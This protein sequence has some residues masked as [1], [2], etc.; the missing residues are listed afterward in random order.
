MNSLLRH[1]IAAAAVGAVVGGVLTTLPAHAAD[2]VTIN[3]VAVNDFHG[4]VDSDVVQ[5]AGTVEQLLAD[6]SAGNSLLLSAGDNV[7]ES[8]PASAAQHDDPTIDILNVLGVDASAVGNHEFDD[9]YDNLVNHIM[10]RADFPIL[11]ANV[12][13]ING[14]AAL[15]ASTMYDVSGVRLAVV[16]AVTEHTPELVPPKGI[17]GLTFGDPVGAINGEVDRLN[18]LPESERPE[19]IVAVIHDGAPWGSGDLNG[20]LRDSSF[21]TSL[22]EDT[23]PDVDAI[24]TGHTHNTYVFDAPV[25]GQSGRTR[26]VIQTGFYGSNVGQI[27]LTVAPDTGDVTAYVA[28]NVARVT[29][30]DDSLIGTYPVLAQVSKIRNDAVAFAKAQAEEAV[31]T[32]QQLVVAEAASQDAYANAEAAKQDYETAAAAG[33][34]F[35][36]TAAKI[37][38]EYDAAVATGKEFYATAAKIKQEYDAARETGRLAYDKAAAI[39][40]EY[41]AAVAAVK[42]SYAT[43]A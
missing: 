42:E 2:V 35:Y 32:K 29:A 10:Q 31:I 26:P 43:A 17:E 25:P 16:G 8:L 3:L 22:V 5:W 40:V 24:I 19:V 20:A 21:F 6:G 33:K 23:S 18:G 38:V 9:G 11:G 28:R 41:D 4:R 37:K 36:A 27:K 1:K 34:E 13:K 14:S 39:K 7:G 12:R 15:D 30:S